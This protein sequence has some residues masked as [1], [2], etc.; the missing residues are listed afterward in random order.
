[1]TNHAMKAQAYDN[2]YLNTNGMI[3]N[4]KE[5]RIAQQSLSSFPRPTKSHQHMYQYKLS[6]R[7]H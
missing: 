4:C 7:P 5:H 3:V 6:S 1:M 2:K